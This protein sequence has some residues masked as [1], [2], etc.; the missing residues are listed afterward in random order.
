MPPSYLVSESIRNGSKVLEA[1][2]AQVQSFVCC[3]DFFSSLFLHLID[4]PVDC[5][6]YDSETALLWQWK[7]R[8]TTCIKFEFSCNLNLFV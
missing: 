2:G 8:K 1:R 5:M 7:P 4:D 3:V 6:I